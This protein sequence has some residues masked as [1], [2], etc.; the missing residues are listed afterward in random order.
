MADVPNKEQVSMQQNQDSSPDPQASRTNAESQRLPAAPTSQR[1]DYLNSVSGNFSSATLLFEPDGLPAQ[2][3]I[4]VLSVLPF[5]AAE[6][7]ISLAEALKDRSAFPHARVEE[8]LQQAFF[9][10]TEAQFSFETAA[11]GAPPTAEQLD[12]FRKLGM[13][14]ALTVPAGLSFD[15]GVVF[16]GLL[17]AVESRTRFLLDQK[18]E[19][20]S[21]ALLGGARVLNPEREI[22]EPL[23]NAI[24]EI[25]FN[26]LAQNNS[27]PRTEFEMMKCV[28]ESF[29]RR[30][31]KLRNIPV[32]EVNSDL[33][34][35][36]V[37]EAP[38]TPDTVVDLANT[39]TS[40]VRIPGLS[41]APSSFLL[42]SSQPFAPRQRE[43]FLA[44]LAVLGYPGLSDVSV[45]GYAA[46]QTPSLKLF[47][48]EIAKWVHAQ[49]LAKYS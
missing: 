35:G 41:A 11:Q 37:K 45:V 32:I 29:C 16:G 10:P 12:V 19:L 5:K 23:S 47:G 2:A 15:V 27:L 25:Y 7:S 49:F 3:L 21:I 1:V 38:G 42:S 48:T 14:E 43:D 9:R 6:Q 39:L 13:I 20:G 24:G 18:A 22:G 26:E 17:G 28:W 31:D 33:R 4:D 40:G 36:N 46:E 34:L 30:D 8:L 44:S